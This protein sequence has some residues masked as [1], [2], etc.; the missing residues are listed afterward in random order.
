MPIILVFIVVIFGSGA[1]YWFEQHSDQSM[2]YA[3]LPERT[4]SGWQNWYRVLP[5]EGFVVGYSDLRLN[6]L[7]VSYP[8]TALTAEQKKQGYKRPSQF[9]EDWRTFWRVSHG[10]YSNTGYDRGHLAPNYAIS[11]QF[12]KQAQL[13]TFLM[14]NISPQKPNLNRKIWQR[15]EEAAIDHFAP[16]FSKVW[17]MTGPVFEG[18]IERLS[19][20][21]EVP[22][23]FYKVFVGVDAKD[24]AVSMLAFFFPQNV[25]GNESLSKFVVSVDQLEL[26]TGFDFFS[27]LDDEVENNL[28]KNIAVQ[29]WR[30]A[31]VASKTSRY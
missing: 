11:R 5:N 30:L 28:E 25:K 15:L 8:L 7:W 29:R 23:G 3:G 6:P 13:D 21:V 16:Q 22:D 20:W 9:N 17:V 10:D 1:W 4:N 27:Q 2:V 14:T 31:E 18:E 19:S 26:M 24:Q 12:G